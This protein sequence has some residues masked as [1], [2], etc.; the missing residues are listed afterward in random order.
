M[1]HIRLGALPQSGRWRAVI[2][3]LGGDADAAGVAAGAAFAAETQLARMPDDPVFQYV[4]DLLVRLPLVARSSDFI[5]GL[6][7]LGVEGAAP[8]SL[9]E[10]LAALQA[11][12]EV[13]ARRI[14]PCNDAGG[15]ATAALLESLSAN[16]EDRVSGLFGTTA[17][18]IRRGLASL[19]SN[20]EFAGLARDFFARL[21]YRSL[22]YY[23][24]REL[25][26]H[27]GP[28]ARFASDAERRRFQQD[29]AN[30]TFEASLIVKEFAGG[31][32]GKT[33][34]KQGTLDRSSIDGFA[35]YAFKK[36]RSELTRRRSDA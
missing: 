36:L 5:D 7:A 14:G 30:H 35:R 19:S 9:P 23:L 1:G 15:L 20:A 21:M 31:W 29:L 25:A 16:L 24:S 34:W 17:A 11:S 33:V 2:D 10:L 28:D 13:E 22:N 27:H 8:S 18:D 3:M 26:N 4:L 12:V 32:Y 6:A